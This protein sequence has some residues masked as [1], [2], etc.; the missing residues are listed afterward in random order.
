MH[1]RS[2][3]NKG[4][5]LGGCNLMSCGGGALSAVAGGSG[6]TWDCERLNWHAATSMC[7]G[8]FN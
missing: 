7:S 3:D 5:E 8:L 2:H 1:S 4:M 6:P